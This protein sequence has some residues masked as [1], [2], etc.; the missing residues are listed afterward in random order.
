MDTFNHGNMFN[1]YWKKI[2]CCFFCC[3]FASSL[4][5][6]I[7]SSDTAPKRW[8]KDNVKIYSTTIYKKAYDQKKGKIGF[9]F[10]FN[11]ADYGINRR[12]SQLDTFN[13]IYVK[14]APGINFGIVTTYKLHTLLDLRAIPSFSLQQRSI[15][16]EQRSSGS[17]DTTFEKTSESAMFQLPLEIKFKSEKNNDF[18]VFLTGGVLLSYNM[19]SRSSDVVNREKLVR[20]YPGDVALSVGFGMDF[21]R[22]SLKLSP[23]IKFAQGLRN[24]LIKEESNSFTQGIQS[25]RS[26]VFMLS[27]IIDW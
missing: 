10:G 20:T 25:L 13:A 12:S 11:I 18:R 6:Q 3:L 23:E 5:A 27:L 7:A 22:E 9:M 19:S 14:S 16:F 15:R 21:Y 1:L 26:Q 24:L 4:F 17:V 8:D 2:T